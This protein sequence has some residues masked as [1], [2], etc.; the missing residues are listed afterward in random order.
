MNII[1]HSTPPISNGDCATPIEKT[2][3][4]AQRLRIDATPTMVRRIPDS[5]SAAQLK[6]DLTEA[7][8][9]K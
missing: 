8:S 4:H 1:R 7:Q 9:N 2:G 5:S 3:A 6:Q